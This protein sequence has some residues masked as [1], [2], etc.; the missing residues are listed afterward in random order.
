MTM[1]SL[2][3]SIWM[4]ASRPAT[5]ALGGDAP[6]ARAA[7]AEHCPL[8]PRAL[9]DDGEPAPA[10][11][12]EGLE[13][14]I[15]GRD[16]P[17]GRREL[18]RPGRAAAA[19][20]RPPAGRGRRDLQSVELPPQQLLLELRDLELVENLTPSLGRRS[21]A[22]WSC[23]ARSPDP[24]DEFSMEAPWTRAPPIRS[25]LR[26]QCMPS[27]RA[28][29]LCDGQWLSTSGCVVKLVYQSKLQ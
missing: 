10:Y 22:S 21:Q 27:A 1:R 16:L 13:H 18:R 20:G 24:L 3:R 11:R 28:T 15:L 25:S 4:P 26:C 19:V 8:V 12:L 23:L 7:A 17:N 14:H 9:V 29:R 6:R 2:A 5:R